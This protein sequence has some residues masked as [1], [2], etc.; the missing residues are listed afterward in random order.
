MMRMMWIWATT[1]GFRILLAGLRNGAEG[2]G[3][4]R[5]GM[6]TTIIIQKPDEPEQE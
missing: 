4:E 6:D 3:R 1:K 2:K 5:S